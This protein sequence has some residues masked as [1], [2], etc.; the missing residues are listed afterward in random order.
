MNISNNDKHSNKSEFEDTIKTKLTQH[1]KRRLQNDNQLV[2]PPKISEL[3]SSNINLSPNNKVNNIKITGPTSNNNCS[4]KNSI[5]KKSK[6]Q[7]T[8][9]VSSNEACD[10]DQQDAAAIPE[11][12]SPDILTIILNQKKLSLMRDPEVTRFF[13]KICN[14]NNIKPP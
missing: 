9:S 4:S 7:K 11:T 8:M 3:N 13:D 10:Q 5:T 1:L 2:Q 12:K 6:L 14:D